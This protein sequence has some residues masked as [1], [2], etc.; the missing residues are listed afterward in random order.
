MNEYTGSASGIVLIYISYGLSVGILLCSANDQAMKVTCPSI[1]E[2]VRSLSHR[3]RILECYAVIQNCSSGRTCSVVP[4]FIF[5]SLS[6]CAC[7]WLCAGGCV[8]TCIPA[9]M[10]LQFS[11]FARVQCLAKY[12]FHT[13]SPNCPQHTQV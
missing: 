2:P 11:M 12:R 5:L 13:T 9:G 6:M 3:R 1:T 7:V 8:L 10:N 4:F